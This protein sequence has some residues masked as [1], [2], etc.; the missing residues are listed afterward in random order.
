MSYSALRGNL[1]AAMDKV[2][3]DHKPIIITRRN[4]KPAVL[5]SAEDFSAYDE[6]AYLMA[7]PANAAR[8]RESIAELEA[9][10]GVEHALIEVA[11]EEEA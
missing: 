6:T 2:N 3:D 9:G 1:A 4:G 10:R 5:M 8:L 11:D 7:S